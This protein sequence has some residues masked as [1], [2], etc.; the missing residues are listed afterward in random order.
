VIDVPILHEQQIRAL[1]DACFAAPFDVLGIHAIDGEDR[2]GRV[3]RALLPWARE[4]WVMRG[5][6]AVPM[7]RLDPAGVF[8]CVWPDAADWFLYRL[9]ARRFDGAI[10]DFE[11][12]YRLAPVLDEGRLYRFHHGEDVRAWEILG[13][14]RLLHEGFEGTLFSIWAPNAAAISVIGSFNGWDARTHPMRPRGS[15]GIWELFLPGIA[16][17]ALYKFA[18]LTRQ[19]QRLEKTDPFAR[20]MEMR[21][22][23]ASVVVDER[24]YDWT[25]A[26]WMQERADRQRAQDRPIS[27]YEVHLGSWRR[28]PGPEGSGDWLWLS[29]RE[30]AETLVPYAKE[31]GFTHLEL[32]PVTEH[33][34]DG[35][36]GYQTLGYFAPTSR[37]GSPDDFRYFVDRAHR[38]GLG[39]IL[40]WVPA[41]FPTDAHGLAW[42]DGT[43]LFEHAD[44][45]KGMHPDWGTLVFNYG[46]N[47]VSSFLTSSALYWIEQFHLDGLRVD[48]VASMLYLD[49]SREEGQ[50]IP[51]Q[52]GGREN[53]EAIAFLKHMNAVVH[54]EHPGALTFAEESTAW[55]G[56]TRPVEWG[57]LGFDL[58]WNMGWMNDTLDYLAHDPLFRKHVHDRLTFSLVYAFSERFL[59]PLSHDEVVHGKR[60]LVSKM[61]GFDPDRFATLRALYGYMWTHPGKKLLFMGCEIGQW[62]EW[63]HEVSL[64][65]HVLE[66]EHH[67]GVQT[68][69]RRLNELL[70]DEPALHECDF[71]SDGFEWVDCHDAD[72]SV[73]SY[74]RWSA[75]WKRC[76]VVVVN[77]T[78]MKWEGYRVG[79]PSGGEW[80]LRLNTA[81][82]EFGGGN[83]L[84]STAFSAYAHE[85]NGRPFHLSFDLP[86]LSTVV[87]T[88]AVKEG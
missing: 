63:N 49:Y 7:E 15:T 78:P 45:R 66:W 5:E 23:S 28:N 35:S 81:A 76:A 79:V 41:H 22:R 6:E 31:M 40:D 50:W 57:G 10:V 39:V 34:F 55:S 33:P 11:D 68:L 74:L 44:P 38:A 1:A 20:A 2:P 75:D 36:W 61:P 83:D 27:I 65:W 42:F 67:R 69:V 72:R 62:G 53:I 3:V 46:R 71:S 52:Y 51:N 84:G 59:L 25:D 70:R 60:A 56:V 8:E 80:S 29:Y 12:P 14:R 30:L 86:P 82:T 54:H 58:K 26:Q 21:P 48:A 32:M 24:T 37:F 87:F 9:R 47:E 43:H 19:G 85:W 77:M 88:R 73:I 16:A 17:G 64:D 18:L 13:A 4:A